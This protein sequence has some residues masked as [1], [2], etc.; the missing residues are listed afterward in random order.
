[1]KPWGSFSTQDIQVTE[2][3][4]QMA[5]TM[6]EECSSNTSLPEYLNNYDSNYLTML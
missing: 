5:I 1:M 3:T 2:I 4:P 6:K